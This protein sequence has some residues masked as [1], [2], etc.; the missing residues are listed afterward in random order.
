MTSFHISKENENMP[1]FNEFENV[2]QCGVEL[3][4]THKVWGQAGLILS[5]R[6]RTC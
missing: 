6:S 4:T 1:T 5:P 2:R 3:K